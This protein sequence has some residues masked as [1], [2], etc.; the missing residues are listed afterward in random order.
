MNY[1][2]LLFEVEDGVAT[3]TMNRPE[4]ANALNLQ[5]AKDLFYAAIECDE[6]PEIRAVVVTGA[7]RLFSGGGDLQ[8]FSQQE[9]L[10]KTLKEMTTFL[11]GA[12]SR[13]VRMAAP[14]I[15]AINGTAGGGGFSLMLG[16]DLAIMSDKAKLT[17]AY[18]AAGLT[19][20]GSSTYFLPRLIG[21]RRANELALTNRR[22]TAQEAL[23]WGLVNQIVPADEV[24]TTAQALAKQ[25]AQGP[26]LAYGKATQ[27]MRESLESSFETQLEVEAQNIAA[28][29]K[30]ADAQEG[31]NS[32]LEKR[33]P[34]F[35][36]E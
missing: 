9:N 10:Q 23:E 26:T 4:A 22:L 27:M 3:I 16:G 32:F 19:P 25:L 14:C 13:L 29:T 12:V 5:M 30:T 6:N 17:M 20:D 11:H 33:K 24:L 7:G 35:K 34:V 1:E 18:T 8:F 36:G 31:V 15:M 21:L 28:I 2:T